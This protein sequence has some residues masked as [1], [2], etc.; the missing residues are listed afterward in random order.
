MLASYCMLRT[1][2]YKIV[3]DLIKKDIED[4]KYAVYDL[5]PNESQLQK[6]F[7]VSRTTVRK[8]MEI[9]ADE[10]YVEIKQGRGTMV[11][12]Y[13]TKQSLNTVTSITESLK[14]RGYEVKTKSMY[15]DTVSAHDFYAEKL[16]I[17]QGETLARIQRIQLAND[18]P[19]TYMKNYI[20]YKFV[21]E[22]EQHTNSFTGLYKLLED[23]YRLQITS[24]KD[25]IFARAADFAE[26]EMLAIPPGTALLCI[27]RVCFCGDDPICIDEVCILGSQYEL[28]VS[29]TG[30]NKIV[31][32]E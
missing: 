18:K 10:G 3:H 29:I 22:I 4:E 5:L 20:P 21:P 23:K 7:N 31:E 2:A 24:A 1:P 9:L 8:A 19:V 15:I 16:N 32:V 28:Q 11:L 6:F 26:A 14:R 12:D 25:V 30:R 17:K 27:H 13:R